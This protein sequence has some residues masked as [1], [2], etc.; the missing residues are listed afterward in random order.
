MNALG[1]K[2]STHELHGGS[3]GVKLN[4]RLLVVEV[5]AYFPYTRH[6]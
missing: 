4:A 6:G 1:L 5:D 2:S 3:L